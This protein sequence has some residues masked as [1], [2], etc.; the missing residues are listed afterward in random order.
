MA[1]EI[2]N[3]VKNQHYAMETGENNDVTITLYGEV[4]D[5]RPYD[6]WSGGKDNGNYIVGSEVIESIDAISDKC[7]KVCLRMDSVG[8]DVHTAILIYNRLRELARKGVAIECSVDGVAMSAGS[9]IMCA[10]DNVSVSEQS[11]IMIHK[12]MTFVYDW[13]NADGLRKM[14]DECDKYDKA[15]MAAY[16]RKTCLSEKEI[17]GM[18]SDTTYLTGA[19]AVEKGFADTLTE[20]DGALDIAACADIKDAITINGKMLHLNGAPAPKGIRTAA[21]S[22]KAGVANTAAKMPLEKSQQEVKSMAKNLTEL[23]AENAELAAEIEKEMK[24]EIEKSQKDETAAAVS[25]AVEQE[26]ARLSEIDAISAL[27]SEEDVKAAKYG[28][29]ACTAAELA[30]RM[31]VANAAKGAKFLNDAQA[32]TNNS[33]VDSVN[34]ASAPETD[35]PHI[36]TEAELMAEAREFMKAVKDGGVKND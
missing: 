35:A 32:D 31:A 22:A 18:M 27:Y 8:G 33:G 24:A 13:I 19:E 5:E 1:K 7:K 12:S 3:A 21:P 36:K 9:M 16:K 4:V 11:L 14:A 23:R 34:A 15:I 2:N 25:K 28:E 10:A 20:S 17:L 26:R 6:W 30:Y 29:K